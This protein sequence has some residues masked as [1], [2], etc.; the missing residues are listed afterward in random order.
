[1]TG[2]ASSAHERSEM[3]G[4]SAQHPAC[5]FAYRGQQS[6][7]PR[8]EHGGTRK[9]LA[10]GMPDVSGATAVNTRAHTSLPIAHELWVHWA[11]GIPRALFSR[12]EKF[13]T[14]LGRHASRDRC[15]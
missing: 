12:G 5:G 4:E 8:G 14:K 1:M 9:T 10:W 15:G 6:G 7:G 2:T 3:R 13:L 11:P